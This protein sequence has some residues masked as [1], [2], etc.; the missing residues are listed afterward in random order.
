M[1][2][3]NNLKQF[4]I[5]LHNYHDTNKYF[6]PVRTSPYTDSKTAAWG[7]VSFYVCLYPFMEQTPRW[8]SVMAEADESHNFNSWA[9]VWRCSASQFQGLISGFGCPSDAAATTPSHI[10]NCQRGSY[11]GS[12]GDTVGMASE[13]GKNQRGCHCHGGQLLGILVP[14]ESFY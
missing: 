5:A 1:Q 2:C 3:T 7:M 12:I 10:N 11:H 4:G 13:T 14:G 9:Q 6:P 8:T